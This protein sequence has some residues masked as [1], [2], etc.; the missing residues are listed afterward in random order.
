MTLRQINITLGTAGHID[1]GKTA[2][3]KNLTGCDTDRLKEEKLRG[4]SI[5]LG[6]AP[7]KI[8]DLQVG[9]VDVPGHEHFIKTMVAGA[10]GMDAVM[11]VVAADD[12]VMPQTREHLDI[13][14]LLGIQRGMVVLTKIDRVLGDRR[15]DV[16][17]SLSVFLRGTF[18]ENAP[19]LPLSNLTGEGFSPFLE[20]V[21]TLVRTTTP[22]RTDGVFRTPLERA[23]SVQGFGTVVAGIP[24]A[25]SASLGDEVVLLPQ[26]ITGR[27]RR[28]EVYGQ[29]SQTVLA[30]QCAAL[31]VGH[32]DQH[33]I[34]RGNTLTV[35]GYFTPAEWCICS[36][37][38]LPQDKLRLKSGTEV[39]L[40]T[41]TTE[42]AATFYSL[43][44][45]GMEGGDQGFVQLRTK[46]PVVVGPG[47]HFLLRM[48]SPART[49]GGGRIVE[50][51]D[52][53]LKA[54]R[55]QMVEDLQ[56]RAETV[57][58]E[59][60]FVEYSVRRAATGAADPSGLAFRTK[61][62]VG[63]IQT[64]LETLV[65]EQKI[66]VLGAKLYIHQ[67]TAAE[68]GRKILDLIG[69][70][71]HRS[72]ESP[73]L[74]VQQLRQSLSIDPIVL[75]GLLVQLTSEGRLVRNGQR[76]ALPQHR[77]TFQEDD[78]RLLNAIEAIFRE[79]P[80]HPPSPEEIARQTG[81]RQTEVE[82]S[83]GLLCEH[84]RIVKVEEGLFFHAEAI[85][86]ACDILV[87]YIN[88]EGRLESVQFKYLL[89]TTRK[90]ALPL[91]DHLDRSGVTRR[92]GNTRFLKNMR[93]SPQ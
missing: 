24:V 74:P 14:T 50:T 35:P 60:R 47:D 82:R 70:F 45:G 29:D 12:G 1:H 64:I 43:Q 13:L 72:P 80:F 75:D 20:A 36:L 22:K 23:F 67:D 53:R 30:G 83:L 58:D 15:A 16:L 69:C 93:S 85:N 89:N 71:H 56:I 17:A 18:L 8:A 57:L 10:N 3:I 41:G 44:G 28:I 68:I 7:C 91:L 32:W 2:L 25:G 27:V 52:R 76:L 61:I 87:A 4:M 38:L 73:G 46:T 48:P 65:K 63:R 37:K 51:T 84:E 39:K 62:P 81:A 19:I 54:N 79:N 86:R 59:R 9:I 31:N 66:R 5:E 6:F 55:P 92:V 21:E 40:H 77:S 90:Y 11:L 42:V 33:A 49:I 26:N 88:K 34:R 78:A